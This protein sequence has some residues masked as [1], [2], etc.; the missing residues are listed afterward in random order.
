MN[1]LHFIFFVACFFVY[2]SFSCF[3]QDQMIESLE[4][5]NEVDSI[6]K[7]PFINSFFIYPNSYFFFNE[8]S[9][10]G[11][12]AGIEK[13]LLKKTS[14]QVPIQIVLN[15]K[16]KGL[17]VGLGYK[18]YPLGYERAFNWSIGNNIRLGRLQLFD[19]NYNNFYPRPELIKTQKIFSV[20]YELQNSLIFKY[21]RIN[22]EASNSLGMNHLPWNSFYVNANF[23][24]G[25]N[26]N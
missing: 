13:N 24:I 1:K 6:K 25:Y 5:Q 18:L 26:L 9:F 2:S 22:F 7:K 3:S 12:G 11:F 19:Y 15:E 4:L 17:F 8:T 10:W 14:L 16:I 21:K 23:V 20:G